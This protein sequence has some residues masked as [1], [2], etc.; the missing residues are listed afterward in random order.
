MVV[1]GM[2][3]NWQP[4]TSGISQGSVLRP[5]L[6]TI[7]TDDPNKGIECTLSKFADDTKTGGRADRPECREVLQR[8]LCKL[9]CWTETR[10]MSF[11]TLVTATSC[12]ATELGQSGWKAV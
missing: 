2:K 6:Y 10:C 1:N 7:F 4:V 12:N 8:N 3:S 11:C 5:A 9:D